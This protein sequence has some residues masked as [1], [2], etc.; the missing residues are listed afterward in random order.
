MQ[1]KKSRPR[2]FPAIC[3]P[4]RFLGRFTRAIGENDHWT[5]PTCSLVYPL[6]RK[7]LFCTTSVDMLYQLFHECMTS[8][9][10]SYL[11]DDE[12]ELSLSG[13]SPNQPTHIY[14][15]PYHGNKPLKR[16]LLHARAARIMKVDIQRFGSC[17]IGRSYPAG[18]RF[19]VH[20]WNAGHAA[21]FWR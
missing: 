2:G 14:L 16:L 9:T 18:A 19:N 8:G 10:G 4:A 13:V 12:E 7:G 11:S 21:W 15:V 5:Y 1:R 6:G 20:V 3:G 17:Q